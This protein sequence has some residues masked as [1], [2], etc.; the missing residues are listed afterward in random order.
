M[1]IKGQFPGNEAHQ[2]F[3]RKFQWK[4]VSIEIRNKSHKVMIYSEE[5]WNKDDIILNIHS[6]RAHTHTHTMQ[7]TLLPLNMFR[8]SYVTS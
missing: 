1:N 7:S 3:T 8:S 4:R 6:I 2:Y 5:E